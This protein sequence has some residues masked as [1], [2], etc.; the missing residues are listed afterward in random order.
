MCKRSNHRTEL[1]QSVRQLHLLVCMN[2]FITAQGH[3]VTMVSISSIYNESHSNLAPVIITLVSHVLMDDCSLIIFFPLL[4]S[5]L[6]P[7]LSCQ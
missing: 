6:S 4:V 3:F 2:Q 1:L 7:L 5:K